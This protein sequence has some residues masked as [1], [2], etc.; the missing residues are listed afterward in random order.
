M[1][2][3]FLR[4]SFEDQLRF[5]LLDETEQDSV[6]LGASELLPVYV[7]N[8]LGTYEQEFISWRDGD[9]KPRQEELREHTLK[10]YAN[11]DRY[12]DLI[13]AVKGQQLVPF[14]GS[15]M[16]VP[17]GLPTWSEFLVQTGD[18]A[19]CDA[20]DLR[21]LVS[22][23]AFE[24]AADLLTSSMDAFLFAERVEHTLRINDTDLIRGAVCLLPSLFPSLVMTTNL[25][26]VL[27]R[28]Y[29]LCGVSFAHSLSGMEIAN[30]RQ[31]YNRRERVLIKLHGDHQKQEGRVLLS[32]E[33]DEAY[34]EGSLIRD[35]A[36]LLCRTN[37][38]LF[39]GCSLRSDRTVR[40]I[41]EIAQANPDMPRHYAFLAK[42]D[43]NS[44]RVA[45]ENFLAARRIFPIWYDLPHDESIMALLEGLEVDRT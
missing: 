8:E 44:E 24:E 43:Q 14:V 17:S 26:N 11:R 45:R 19:A 22:C 13:E 1:L 3:H 5:R 42:P 21:R 10:Y 15:G 31:P 23:S 30:L 37:N 34:A 2:D 29:E 27:Q 38:L 32:K 7:A 16:S 4:T 12:L 6:F 9:W 33:Y 40:L 36:T 41:Y 18:H 35:R 39:L 20:S 28:L 25:D